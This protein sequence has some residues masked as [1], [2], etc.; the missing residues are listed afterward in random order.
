MEN[1]INYIE[2]IGFTAAVM[3]TFAFLPQLY[4]TW[5][6]KSA[7]DVSETTLIMFISGLIFWIFYGIK[8]N[9]LP[10]LIANSITLI[11]N[12]SILALKITAKKNSKS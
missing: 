1:S 11:L 10:I 2:F 5:S 12:G 7:D 9:S 4:K 6:S 8:I 3:T